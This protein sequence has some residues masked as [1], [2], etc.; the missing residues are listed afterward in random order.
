LIRYHAVMNRIAGTLATLATLLAGLAG[1]IALSAGLLGAGEAPGVV[2]VGPWKMWPRAGA[3]DADPY[4]RAHFARSGEVPL[5]P[6]E[7]L[8]LHADSDSS[9]RPL[10]GACS[11]RIA[12]RIPQARIWTLAAYAPDGSLAPNPAGRF[13]L[14]AAEAVGGGAG[15]IAVSREP[16]PGD[17]LPIGDLGRFVLVLRLYDTPLSALSSALDPDI[18]PRI[19][20]LGCA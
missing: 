19:E 8:A 10:R 20:R 3:P 18:A 7:G 13:V 2:H 5:S 12:G 9:G 11:Y 17:W 4:A 15:S 1:G 6:A 14:T 16:Q